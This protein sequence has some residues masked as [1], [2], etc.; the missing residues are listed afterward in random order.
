MKNV[1]SDIPVI[2]YDNELEDEFSK[3]V[4]TPRIIDERYDYDGGLPRR[5][6]RLFFYYIIARPVG[7]LALKIIYRHKIINRK[8]LKGYRDTGFFLYGNHTNALADPVI[9]SM[10][11]FPKDV[12]IIA[13]ANN[14]SMPVLGRINPSL[15]AIPLPDTK[16]AVKGFT[17]AVERAI[18]GRSC[19]T[20]YPE[21]HIWPYYTDIRN[22]KDASFRYPVKYDKPVF[23]FTNTYQKRR[24]KHIR[25]VTYVEGPFFPD[26]TLSIKDRKKDLRDRVYDAMKKNTSHNNVILVKY[27]RRDK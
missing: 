3:A 2:Y 1:S 9:P 14:V 17:K 25:M 23:C 4:I 27:E 22:F 11:T 21:A 7:Y 8:C 26:N 20:I 13:H 15:G 5:I 6:G 10:I 12:Y 16:T 24:G 19:V 18:E